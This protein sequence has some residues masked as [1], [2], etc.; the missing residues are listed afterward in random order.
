MQ[1]TYQVIQKYI[2]EQEKVDKKK[3]PGIGPPLDFDLDAGAD[4]D[5]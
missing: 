3:L 4:G 1:S 5:C 2:I